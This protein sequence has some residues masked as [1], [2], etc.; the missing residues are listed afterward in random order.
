MTPADDS[1]WHLA[2]GDP[3]LLGWVTMVAYLVAGLA[4][5]RA[6][7][8]CSFGTRMLLTSA[9]A[10]ARHQERLA[11]WWIGV[12]AL[13]IL[14]GLN[15]QLDL[16]TLLTAVGKE[17]A[18]AQGWYAGRKQVKL[19]FVMLLGLV[20][21]SLGLV[22]AY[23]LRR[24]WRRLMPSLLGLV[25]ILGFV[26][27]RAVVFHALSVA[28]DSDVVTDPWYLELAGVGLVLWDAHRASRPPGRAKA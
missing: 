12:G 19:A 13:M 6:H 10:E 5:W 27:V 11:S 14:L 15:K 17:M 2:V 21:G 7:R 28:P 24:V 3:T 25:L 1:R 9:P 26:E 4:C 23:A 8:F 18:L 20:L 22:V 16:Q